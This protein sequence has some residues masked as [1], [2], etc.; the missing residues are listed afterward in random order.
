M[1][2][3]ILKFFFC[4]IWPKV[5]WHTA[6]M[7][8]VA[9]KHFIA[10]KTIQDAIRSGREL[11][12]EG[13][14]CYF[15]HIGDRCESPEERDRAR[16][17]Y[18]E[19]IEAI[20]EHGLK[21]GI[22]T[23]ASAL[24]MLNPNLHSGKTR[25]GLAKLVSKARDYGIPFW[26]DGEEL[27]YHKKTT[28]VAFFARMVCPKTGSVIQAYTK[29]I[30]S[31]V[32]ELY[33]TKSAFPGVTTGFRICKGAYTEPKELA[34]SDIN[35]IRDRFEF[36]VRKVVE[37]KHYAQVATHDEEIIRRVIALEQAGKIRRD[38]FEFALLLGVNMPLAKKLL[39]RGYRV[40]IYVPFG[41][42]VEG[43]CVRRIIERPRY[44]ILPLKAIFCK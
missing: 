38:Q 22:S 29:N 34:Y 42:D 20:N 4:W 18:N 19:L 26:L 43:F 10:G 25:E 35:D 11:N 17:S 32:L 9:E 44:I 41:K 1:V 37:T 31:I 33:R 24:G 13:F 2:R 6:I 40:I 30:G 15:N 14:F 3:A 21:A 8:H 28:E 7:K 23:K 16:S 12:K 27:I 39:S 5:P 36:W